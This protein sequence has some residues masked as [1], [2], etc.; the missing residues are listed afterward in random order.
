MGM[1]GAMIVL[2]AVV[3]AFVVLRDINRTDPESPVR[4]VEYEQTARFARQQ[5]AIEVVAPEPLPEGWKVTSVEFVPRPARWHLGQLT[6]EGK[7]V[8]L[9]QADRSPES[10]VETYVDQ[11]ATRGE[12]VTV[13]GDSWTSWTDAGGDTA[14]VR[15][16]GSTTTL[17]VGTADQRVLV[18]YIKTLR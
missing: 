8:G 4:A 15:S 18:D 1:V 9:E 7:Y 11:D 13:E 2:V 5:A 14:L 16:D 17:V 12:E 10:M 3:L 6:D